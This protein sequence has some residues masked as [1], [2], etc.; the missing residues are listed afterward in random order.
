[1]QHLNIILCLCVLF[2]IGMSF[3]HLGFVVIYLSE[4]MT[5]GFTTGCSIHVFSSQLKGIFGVSIPRHSGALKLIYTYR[6]LIL[7]LPQTNPAAVIASVISAVLLWVT[8]EYLNP[9]VKKRLKAPIP[10]DLVVVR[11]LL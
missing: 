10:I 3:L 5:R 7:A 2:Q 11:T 6:D 4:P 8:K 9:P 1:M